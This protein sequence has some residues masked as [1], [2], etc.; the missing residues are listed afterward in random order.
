MLLYRWIKRC[1]WSLMI[2]LFVCMVLLSGCGL[3]RQALPP[4]MPNPVT[5]DGMTMLWG[6]DVKV[7]ALKMISGSRKFC[8]FSI[9]ELG[10]QDILRALVAA[11]RRGVNVQVVVDATE[12]QSQSIAVPTLEKAGIS[13]RSLKVT[14]GISHIKLLVVDQKNGLDAMLGGMNFGKES[15]FNHDASVFFHQTSSGFE[16]VFQRDYANALGTNRPAPVYPAPLL[17]DRH[18]EAAM[19]QAIAGAKQSVAIEAFALTSKPFIQALLAAKARGVDVRVAL[20]P[21]SSYQ[22]KTANQLVRAGIS[23]CFYRP[24]QDELLHAKIMSIDHGKIFF[25]GSSN[26]SR[27]AFAI[28]HEG[29]VRLFDVYGFGASVDKD[30]TRIFAE[31]EAA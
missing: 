24:V 16:G 1:C 8:H 2:G 19:I 30:M 4:L 3:D 29:D 22:K 31:S 27:Q 11:N 18:I 5:T 7:Q 28:N 25:I 23:T 21:H 17:V 12:T 10:D 9:Y 26:F 6:P 20:D 14:G 13:V 15:L